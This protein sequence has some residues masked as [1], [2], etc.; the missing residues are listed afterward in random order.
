M[1][2]I[3][4][5]IVFIFSI[6]SLSQNSSEAYKSGSYSPDF[7]MGYQSD[8]IKDMDLINELNKVSIRRHVPVSY[9]K[10]KAHIFGQL[11]LE[12]MGSGQYGVTDVY[13]ERQFTDQ[14]FGKPT[15][16]PMK[17]PTS[18]DIM[19][20][21]HTWPQSQFTSQY[22]SGTQKA[23]L[24][25]LFPTD[26][27][28]NSSRSNFRFGEV[29]KESTPLKCPTAQLGTGVDDH[30]LI[31]EAPDAH[32]GNTARALFYFAVRYK[33]SITANEERYLRRWDKEDPID[34]KERD[35]NDQIEKIQGNRNP[36][37]D[38][39]D[40]VDHIQSFNR[41]SY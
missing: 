16:G 15:F 9:D 5:A 2:L 30:S 4:S 12:E 33:L 20:T 37:I 3:L 31:F 19:N 13:C 32:K 27:K 24:H 38:F 39:P 17:S 28:M 26:S 29:A 14:D 21:E 25:H 22:P 36:F 10:A 7:I 41:K 1:K 34:E 6:H 8:Q 35:R 23:D 18:G 40:L 11:F